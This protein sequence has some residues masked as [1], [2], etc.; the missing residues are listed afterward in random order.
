M[1]LHTSA[2]LKPS[3]SNTISTPKYDSTSKGII[4]FVFREG[5]GVILYYARMELNTEYGI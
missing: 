3:A 1:K 5:D 2:I 4:K